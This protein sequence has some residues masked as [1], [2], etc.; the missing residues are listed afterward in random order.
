[1]QPTTLHRPA[2]RFRVACLVLVPVLAGVAWFA[3]QPRDRLCAP[4]SEFVLPALVYDEFDLSAM[5]LRGLNADQDRLAGRADHPYESWYEPP[6]ISRLAKDQPLQPRY[7]LEYP[8]VALLLFRAGYWIQPSTPD[9]PIPAGLADT[10]YHDIAAHTP[11]N[12]D[13]ARLWRAFVVATR[14][15]VVVM[16]I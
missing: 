8:H 6:L 1:M 11:T 15:Y 7:F 3:I 2:R 16:L 13:E 9:V 14:F 10:D 12:A 4:Y 5:A